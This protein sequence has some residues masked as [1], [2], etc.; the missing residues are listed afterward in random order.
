MNDNWSDV[1]AA[2]ESLWEG[3]ST[4]PVP[5]EQEARMRCHVMSLAEEHDVR[6]REEDIH[7]FAAEGPLDAESRS[8]IVPRLSS[9]LA[10]LVALHEIG[11]LAL[12]LPSYEEDGTTR[13]FANEASV[14]EWAIDASLLPPS[15]DAVDKIRLTFV[16]DEP[17]DGRAAARDRV[18]RRCAERRAAQ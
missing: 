12:R 10:Y 3:P 4:E 8:V 2:F 6:C 17:R 14:W 13:I 11:H 1:V 16:V 18:M 5:D 9:E 7:V 15:E